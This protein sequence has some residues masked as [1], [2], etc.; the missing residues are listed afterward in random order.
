LHKIGVTPVNRIVDVR[1]ARVLIRIPALVQ[2]ETTAA[3]REQ[4]RLFG[5]QKTMVSK[6]LH[7]GEDMNRGKGESG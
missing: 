3:C 4:K 7:T 1:V 2:P 6:D 5:S